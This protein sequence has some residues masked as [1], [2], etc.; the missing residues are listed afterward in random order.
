MTNEDW[1]REN[2]PTKKELNEFWE[3]SYYRRISIY[4]E[5]D[6]F[7]ERFIKIGNLIKYVNK[8]KKDLYEI[9]IRYIKL[10]SLDKILK[11]FKIEKPTNKLWIC[12]YG[13]IRSVTA[14]NLFGGKSIGIHDRYTSDPS[15]SKLTKMEQLCEWANEIYIFEDY[16]CANKS[17]NKDY[18][19]KHWYKFKDKIKLSLF[20]PDEYGKVDHPRLIEKIKEALKNEI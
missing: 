15:Q 4:G 14:K 13:Q 20:I 17:P 8:N 12:S 18:F 5:M 11:S 9:K 2:R 6:R 19:L 3:L 10:F 7:I 16:D 1:I